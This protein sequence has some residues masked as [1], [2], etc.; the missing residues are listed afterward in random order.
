M[1]EAAEVTLDTRGE[2]DFDAA[3]VAFAAS[4]A[5]VVVIGGTGGG[6]PRKALAEDEF[7]SLLMNSQLEK[8]QKNIWSIGTKDLHFLP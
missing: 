2:E 1:L 6:G 7:D 8:Y 3:C 5:L 4:M